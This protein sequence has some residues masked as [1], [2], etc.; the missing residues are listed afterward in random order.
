M[1]NLVG[2]RK[3]TDKV[4]KGHEKMFDNMEEFFNSVKESYRIEKGLHF[5]NA[6]DYEFEIFNIMLFF[7]EILDS[8]GSDVY[9]Y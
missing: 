5:F 9:L 1:Q 3:Q 7:K 6:K 8:L 2:N 4:F